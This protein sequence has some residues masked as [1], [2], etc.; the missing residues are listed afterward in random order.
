MH[1]GHDM[2][3][4]DP[5]RCGTLIRPHQFEND[6]AIRCTVCNRHIRDLL[7]AVWDYLEVNTNANMPVR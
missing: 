4:Y 2:E 1:T 3:N 7:A 5:I 6:K